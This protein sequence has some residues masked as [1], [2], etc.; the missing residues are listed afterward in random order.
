M[1]FRRGPRLGLLLLR[2][3]H[4]SIY[5]CILVFCSCVPLEMT[6]FFAFFC[7][8]NPGG[9]QSLKAPGADSRNR[10]EAL[11][12][13]SGAVSTGAVSTGAV[14]A[15]ACTRNL[16]RVEW[17]GHCCRKCARRRDDHVRL[18]I[19]EPFLHGTGC[20]VHSHQRK[21]RYV[22]DMSYLFR[23]CANFN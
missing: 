15:G 1:S 13:E 9:F 3:G 22:T 7:D 8:E 14:S 6:E 18:R 17:G 21:H 16:H 2:R 11:D 20:T 10:K 12:S 23:Y 4:L 19:S 5:V